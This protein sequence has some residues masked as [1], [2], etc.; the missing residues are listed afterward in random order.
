M[1]K[2][3][4]LVV[5]DEP[6]NLEIIEEF[7]S[8][9][10]YALTMASDGAEAW[11]ILQLDPDRFSAILLDRM[12]PN[13]DGMAL[14]AKLKSEK[15]HRHIPIILQTAKASSKD[16][17]EGINAG[18]H[19]YLTKPF[20]EANL[21]SMLRSA[22]YDHALH[23][24]LTN[25]IDL[26]SLA[27][28]KLSHG[29]MY[30]TFRTLDDGKGVATLL[31][32]L[33][34]DPPKVITGL[35]ELMTNAIEHGTLGITYEEKTVLLATNSW[36]EE[37]E[38]RQ[39]LSENKDKQITARYMKNDTHIRINIQDS[40][41]G[42]NWTTYLTLDP[43]RAFDTHGRGIAMANLMSFDQ[44]IYHGCGNEVEAIIEL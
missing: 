11:D 3:P 29:E 23:V 10:P 14:L 37:V 4:I 31:A 8:D 41:P 5:D 28:Q 30:F 2:H 26:C 12:M 18:A 33:C 19:Y 39:Q 20:D 7:L 25:K 43:S 27:L 32:N 22:L 38:E 42:F 40:G 13:M 16:I 15:T 24:D 6:F 35:T 21:K 34:P 44:L 9:E 17:M 1:K 36:A